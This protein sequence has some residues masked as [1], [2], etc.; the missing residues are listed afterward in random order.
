MEPQEE[1]NQK[2]K[3][4]AGTEK[5]TKLIRFRTLRDIC[6]N[7]QIIKEGVEIEL[8]EKDAEPFLVP[9]EGPFTH[10]GYASTRIA[11]RAKITRLQRLN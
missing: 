6:V 3:L 2:T 4:V 9:I 5:A 10:N 11:E 8:S 1:M 7:D